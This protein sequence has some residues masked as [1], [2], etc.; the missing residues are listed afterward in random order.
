[1]Q[2]NIK[3]KYIIVFEMLILLS[4]FIYAISAKT[5]VHYRD[6]RTIDYDNATHR[7]IANCTRFFTQYQQDASDTAITVIDGVFAVQKDT[8][9]RPVNYVPQCRL[10]TCPA[11]D[12]LCLSIRI[13]NYTY[14]IS[15][16]GECQLLADVCQ[17]HENIKCRIIGGDCECKT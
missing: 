5:N 11:T 13:F 6:C 16:K 1:M 12:P 3:L 17:D 8:L 7:L 9:Y 15:G 10:K 14:S 2:E 4:V